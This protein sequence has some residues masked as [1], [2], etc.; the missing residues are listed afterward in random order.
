M[1]GSLHGITI[2]QLTGFEPQRKRK[3]KK[4]WMQSASLVCSVL[5]GRLPDLWEG[6]VGVDVL[7]PCLMSALHVCELGKEQLLLC[8]S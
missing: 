6:H 1:A 5:S 8:I 2:V 3:G 4:E 7:E